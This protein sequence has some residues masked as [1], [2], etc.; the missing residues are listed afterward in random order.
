MSGHTNG[1]PFN[2]EK[3]KEMIEFEL[4]E[5]SPMRASQ[6][7]TGQFSNNASAKYQ[8]SASAARHAQQQPNH[9]PGS[10]SVN[11]EKAYE[12]LE[13]EIQEIKQKLHQSIS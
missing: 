12:D 4:S 1:T 9:Q 11:L 2:G 13:K 5:A 10:S 8:G 3:S 7:G 6:Y